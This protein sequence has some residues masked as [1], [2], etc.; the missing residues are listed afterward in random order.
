MKWRMVVGGCVGVLLPLP[1]VL[2]LWGLLRPEV[3]AEPP[4]EG[5]IS[6]MLDREQRTRLTTYRRECRSGAECEPPL[7]CLYESRYRQAYCT[8]SQCM[9]D[10]QCPEDHVC[11]PLATEE[12]GL[13]VRI[14]V[15]IGVRQEGENCAPAPRDKGHG[16]AAG[17]VCGGQDY[18]WCGRPCRLGD[19]ATECPEGFFCAATE[20][21]PACQPTCEGRT[22]PTGQHCTRFKEGASVCAVVYGPNCQESPCPEGQLCRVLTSPLHAGKAWMECI[23]RCGRGFPPCGTGKICDAWQCVPS[24]D[25]QD[26]AACP[27]GF[28][29]R[30][31][32]PDSPFGCHPDW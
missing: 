30:Q 3:P 15:P 14:C 5:R 12:N 19:G 17:L 9:T 13:L 21:E 8:D 27:K 18:H 22:C 31:P 20:P 28:R 1:L 16:C 23:E 4:R 7:G 29:C 11:L 2:L 6:P 26:S 24:C 10:T 25:L 32:W